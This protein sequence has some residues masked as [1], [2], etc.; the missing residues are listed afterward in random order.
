MKLLS[1]ILFVIKIKPR[2]N[3]ETKSL[4]IHNI[5]FTG[6]HSKPIQDDCGSVKP[7]I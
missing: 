3:K 2:L 1:F 7:R 6:D 5:P 4:L